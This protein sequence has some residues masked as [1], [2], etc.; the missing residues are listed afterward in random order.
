MVFGLLTMVVAGAGPEVSGAAPPLRVRTEFGV[1]TASSVSPTFLADVGHSV[2]RPSFVGRYIASGSAVGSPLS[3]T[4][5]ADIHQAGAAVML[6]TSPPDS[7]LTTAGAAVS[8]AGAAT[9]AARA[10]G[11]PAG[12][13]IFREVERRYPVSPTYVAA[14]YQVVVSAGYVPGFY[15]TSAPGAAFDGA[16]CGAVGLDRSVGS[17]TVLFAA[18]PRRL[19]YRF[20]ASNRPKWAPAVPP[21]AQRTV[22]WQYKEDFGTP[23]VDVDEAVAAAGPVLWAPTRTA[24]A[25]DGVSASASAAGTTVTVTA[26]PAG[27][28][29]HQQVRFTVEVSD[30]AAH[31]ALGYRI[32]YGDGSTGT[33]ALPQYCTAQGRAAHSTWHLVHRYG[34]PGSYRIRVTG[35]AVCGGGGAVARLTL[36]IR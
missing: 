5:V 15:E 11:A 22:A 13:A 3:R 28:K 35:V 4:E 19:A 14:W 6:L 29:V 16:Y 33:V 12:V 2:G 34:R 8:E 17:G 23:N 7:S 25:V 20:E 21:C 31:G 32:S 10:L 1:D 9:D 24:R 27:P 30:A 18:T 26:S 36:S